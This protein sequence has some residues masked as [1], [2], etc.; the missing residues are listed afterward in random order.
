MQIMGNCIFLIVGCSGSGKTTITE[1]L[2]QKYGLKSIQSYTTRPKRSEN[3]TGH[4]FVTNKEFDK[5]TDMVAYTEFAG[6]RYCATTEQVENNDIYIIDPKG[7]DFFMKSYNGRKTPKVIFISSDM[8]TRYE[9]MKSRAEENG[10]EFMDAVKSSL[11]RITNDVVEFYDYIHNNAHV[12]FR[13]NNNENDNLNQIVDKIY[14]YI[15][16]C[17]RR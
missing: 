7:I 1:Q 12:D 10:N 6:N 2:E 11:E 3:E 13:I 16:E 5:L 8:A 17:E 9:R 4:I 14:Q 15:C